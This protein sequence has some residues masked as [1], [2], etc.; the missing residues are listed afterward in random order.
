MKKNFKWSIKVKEKLESHIVGI[1]ILY[2]LSYLQ[3]VLFFSNIK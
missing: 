1:C 2:N 3:L